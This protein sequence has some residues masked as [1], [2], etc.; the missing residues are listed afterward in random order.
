MTVVTKERGN[1][2]IRVSVFDAPIVIFG[3]SKRGGTNGK[4]KSRSGMV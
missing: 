4:W 1:K 3:K 2:N